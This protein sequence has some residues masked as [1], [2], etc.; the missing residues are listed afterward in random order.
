MP[1]GQIGRGLIEI[2]AEWVDHFCSGKSPEQKVCV[3]LC[4]SVVKEI[5][6]FQTSKPETLKS[7]EEP[8]RRY[9]SHP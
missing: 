1:Y 4:L 6:R 2:P 8:G 5:I 3:S 7:H 9:E